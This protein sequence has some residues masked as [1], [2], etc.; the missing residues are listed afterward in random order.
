[1]KAIHFLFL[2]LLF[3]LPMDLLAIN[4]YQIGDTLTVWAQSGLNLRESDD[5]KSKVIASIPFGGLVIAENSK[6]QEEREFEEFSL[7]ETKNIVKKPK[8]SKGIRIR[9]VWLKVKYGN[10]VGYLFDGY[11]SSFK[12]P[13]ERI[14]YGLYYYLKRNFSLSQTLKQQ[15]TGPLELDTGIEELVFEG[16]IYLERKHR[17]SWSEVRIVFPKLSPEEG[18]LLATYFYFSQNNI[19]IS[20]NGQIS[21]D[22]EMGNI[23]LDC[24]QGAVIITSYYSN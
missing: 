18:F 1:M 7:F 4:E 2:S 15:G 19:Y 17:L 24:V 6:S 12:V 10:K 3:V 14:D 16:G 5:S 8:D 21:F 9:G 22:Q 23:T 13:A 20:E 11:L